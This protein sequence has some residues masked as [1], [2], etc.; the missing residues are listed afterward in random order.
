MKVISK[1]ELNEDKTH[2]QLTLNEFCTR[3]INEDEF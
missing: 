3:Q 1:V 2:T